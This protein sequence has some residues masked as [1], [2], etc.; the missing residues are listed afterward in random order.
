MFVLLLA[1]ELAYFSYN[2]WK[3]NRSIDA[4]ATPVLETNAGKINTMEESLNR[5][6][7]A[8]RDR[9]GSVPG[10]SQNTSPVVQ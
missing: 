10:S 8:L 2:F 6:E 1:G 4:P 5:V 9:T 7:A 3:T